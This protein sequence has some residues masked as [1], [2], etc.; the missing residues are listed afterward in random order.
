MIKHIIVLDIVGLE[1][2]HIESG[3]LPNIGRLA[4]HGEAVKM[5]PVFPALTCPVQ[6]SILS[7]TYPNRHGIIANGLYD[8]TKYEVS[9][10]EQ[11]SALVQVDRIW[12]IA[13]RS[14]K[15]T[16]KSSSTSRSPTSS[17][18]N[19]RTAVLFWQNTMYAESDIVVSPRPLHFQDRMEMWCYSK[20]IGYYDD[21]LKQKLGEFNLANYWGPLA[22]SKSSEWI[23]NAAKYILE[24]ERPNIMFAYIPHVD[25]SAQ[26][27]GKK[28]KQV[29]EDL[30]KADDIVGDIV[31]K[32]ARLGIYGDTQ[33]II[34][35]EYAFNDVKEAVPLNLRLR[36]KGLLV[37]R[38]INDREYI[39]Y[40]YSN[41]FAM[42]DH[43]IAH[44]YIK[45]GFLDQT[46]R[47][48]EDTHGVDRILSGR[49]KNDLKI[50]HERSGELIAISDRDKWFSYYWWYSK[51]KAPPFATTVDI[52]RKP[53]YDPVELFV[54]PHTKSI[55]L[56]T[57]LIRA[58]HGRP[59]D[60]NT[61]E[62]YSLCVSN[63]KL[64]N[65]ATNHPAPKIAGTV[66]CVGIGQ[67]LLKLVS[68]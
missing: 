66:E 20:P 24:N 41:A 35:S 40:E 32:T 9:F 62:G 1:I 8:R 26:R 43:Q 5:E 13:K 23:C 47:A 36:D 45:D 25:Y 14:N 2:G 51:D 17:F 42:V 58:S 54:D 57:S 38:T 64:R 15:S 61:E 34:L 28:S 19:P 48:L 60:A 31:D 67:Y 63:Y 39:D 3:I 10:W 27:F 11:S 68:I 12:D 56:D 44:V 33:F 7:G 21:Q 50:D 53:G 30:G 55:P 6:S 37:T 29:Q 46:K 4:A 52:H 65:G 16:P 49:E 22:S 18:S 59:V